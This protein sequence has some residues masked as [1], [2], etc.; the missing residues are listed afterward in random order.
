MKLITQILHK[1]QNDLDADALAYHNHAQRVYHYA[2]VLLLVRES[3]KI[4]IAAAF[5]DLDIWLSQSMDYLQGS[6]S[7]ARKYLAESDF[8]LL[9][10]EVSFIISS[11]HKLTKIKGNIEAEAFRKADLIDLTGG[12]VRYNIPQ[13][14]ISDTERAYPRAGFSRLMVK[15]S[16]SHAI[17]HPLRPF[18]MVKW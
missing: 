14:I 11:H 18:P 10:D 7:L 13:S 17:R 6:Q 4:A 15:K 16:L 1:F 2:T 5:H 12:W 9:P 3:K 8:Q